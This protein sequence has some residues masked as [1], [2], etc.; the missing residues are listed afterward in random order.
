[1]PPKS[2]I[3]SEMII[4][5]AFEIIRKNG[6]D[7]LNVRSIAAKLCCST[8][9]VMYCFKTVEDIRKAVYQRADK[10]HSEYIMEMSG[11]NPLLSIGLNYIKFAVE[12]KPLFRFLFQSDGFGGKSLLELTENEQLS[13][14]IGMFS[15]AAGI[16]AEKAC[17]VFRTV[18]LYVHGVASML[19][20]NSMEYN[21]QTIALELA[22]LF[23][24]ITGMED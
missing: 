16:S 12:E 9:P 1:M 5:A 11:E 24:A 20:N 21:E 17:Y 23:N 15:G 13:P 4:T 3:T 14:I 19:A 10:F 8:Q 18:F 7:S 2:R 6:G 22:L